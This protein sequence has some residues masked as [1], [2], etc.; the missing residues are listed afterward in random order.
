MTNLLNPRRFYFFSFHSMSLAPPRIHV[1][2]W[3]K[4]TDAT[5]SSRKRKLSYSHVILDDRSSSPL[6]FGFDEVKR[7]H[8]SPP[9]S[10]FAAMFLE[11][12]R[13]CGDEKHLI[14][15]CHDGRQVHRPRPLDIPRCRLIWF[16]ILAESDAVDVG[17]FYSFEQEAF[18]LFPLFPW[19]RI[20][21]LQQE[22]MLP[23]GIKR[24]KQVSGTVL[25]HATIPYGKAKVELRIPSEFTHKPTHGFSANACTL[26]SWHQMEKSVDSVPRVMEWRRSFEKELCEL[27]LHLPLIAVDPHLPL[28]PLP[29]HTRV[30]PV[31]RSFEDLYLPVIQS[32]WIAPMKGKLV[33]S[34]QVFNSSNR[35][36]TKHTE[37]S[38]SPSVSDETLW[39]PDNGVPFDEDQ[40]SNTPSALSIRSTDPYLPVCD[41]EVD[42]KCG[43]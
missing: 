18:V 35:C 3:N 28:F 43:P 4:E 2:P 39:H 6:R 14:R 38:T 27:L 19:K 36:A 40:V 33:L 30:D 17:L 42:R 13:S 37:S 29:A 11:R 26:F 1:F 9:S 15:T 23:D 25:H 21:I 31:C 7:T 34:A 22:L 8:T 5:L 41:D 12:I 32:D 16:R 24:K 10:A 20:V